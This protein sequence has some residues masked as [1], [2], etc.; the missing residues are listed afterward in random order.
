MKDAIPQSD[1]GFQGSVAADKSVMSGETVVAAVFGLQAGF[2]WIL[3]VARSLSLTATV[4]GTDWRLEMDVSLVRAFCTSRS[5][6]L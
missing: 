1:K 5:L 3:L 6:K 2:S 4:R